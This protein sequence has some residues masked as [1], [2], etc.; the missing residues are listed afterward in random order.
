MSFPSQTHLHPWVRM[1]GDT[2]GVFCKIPQ[3]GVLIP[4]GTLWAALSSIYDIQ[5]CIIIH[6]KYDFMQNI[7][8]TGWFTKCHHDLSSEGREVSMDSFYYFLWKEM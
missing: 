4:S 8:R 5:L 3:V 1:R 7:L 6:Y 2:L